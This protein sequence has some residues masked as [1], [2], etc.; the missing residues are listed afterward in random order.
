MNAAYTLLIM[1]SQLLTMISGTPNVSD[2]LRQQGIQVAHYAIDE[3]NRQ[4]A[5]LNTQPIIIDTVSTSTPAQP[6]VQNNE[7][8]IYVPY[9][10]GTAPQVQKPMEDKSGITVNIVNTTEKDV[11][12]SVPFGTYTIRVR[13]LDTDG[14]STCGTYCD[15]PR[16]VNATKVPIS[17]NAPDNQGGDIVEKVIDGKET[18]KSKDYYTSFL[19]V[20]TKKGNK[21]LTF[22][23]GDLTKDLEINVQ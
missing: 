15:N 7:N 11:I 10:A 4:L 19:Y 1:A 13:V 6:P 17:M 8:V 22:T 20:P 23:S 14:N 9:Y 2:A 21:N 5:I 3:A 12:N 18:P 16:D